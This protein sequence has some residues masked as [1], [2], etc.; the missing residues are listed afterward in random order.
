MILQLATMLTCFLFMIELC[1]LT[2]L[3]FY[4][5]GMGAFESCH[6]AKIPTPVVITRTMNKETETEPSNISVVTKETS[7]DVLSFKELL[8]ELQNNAISNSELSPSLL[9]FGDSSIRLVEGENSSSWNPWEGQ[10]FLNITSA[11]RQCSTTMLSSNT[12]V[13]L[14]NVIYFYSYTYAVFLIVKILTKV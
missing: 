6:L 9:L 2:I 13:R 10:Q 12:A 1:Y 8:L 11:L 3:Y 5:P 14:S 7:N 4:Q